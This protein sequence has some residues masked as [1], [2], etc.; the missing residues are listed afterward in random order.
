MTDA[1][2]IRAILDAPDDDVPRLVY[3]DWL[4]E[5]GDAARSEF[6]RVQCE[7]ATCQLAQDP[8]CVRAHS[9]E[10]HRLPDGRT[11]ACG[12]CW[13]GHRRRER[14]LLT[15]RGGDWSP[16]RGFVRGRRHG[17]RLAESGPTVEWSDRTAV[18]F[19]RGF[20]SS[21]TLSWADWATHAKH[22]LAAAPIARVNRP[23]ECMACS[24][25]GPAHGRLAVCPACRG[26][27]RVDD[28]KGDGRVVLSSMPEVTWLVRDGD[29]WRPSPVPTVPESMTAL[30]LGDGVENV[31]IR[32]PHDIPLAERVRRLLDANWKGVD[33]GLPAADWDTPARP[34]PLADIQALRDQVSR[35]LVTTGGR[36]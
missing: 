2:F 23:R 31:S 6:V 13:D 33:F 3:A 14:E 8:A 30:R 5:R 7:L 29:H 22:L 10:T 15:G 35:H 34:T 36:P 32:V 28:W 1:A 12:T 20:V 16:S 11:G 4:D 17:W 21:V 18:T 19:T 9:V 25:G 27:G 26:T 24:E